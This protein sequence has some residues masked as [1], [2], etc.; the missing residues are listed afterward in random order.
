MHV[1]VQ[2]ANCGGRGHM[3]RMCDR[4]V[5]SFGVV[6]FRVRAGGSLEYMLVQRKD[7]LAYVEFIRGK[8]SLMNTDYIVQMLSNMTRGEQD[9][10]MTCEGF[11]E[12]WNEFW[13]SDTTRNFVKEYEQSSSR[14]SALW[15]GYVT[16]KGIEFSLEKALIECRRL[17][18]PY[19]ETEFGFPKGRRNINESDVC[20][21]CREFSEET[22]MSLAEIALV[23]GMLPFEETFWGSNHVRYRHTYFV[24]KY[25][26]KDDEVENAMPTNQ[27][28]E[29][30]L[31][32]PLQMREI[33]AMG[34]FDADG[35][36]ARLRPHY[37]ERRALFRQIHGLIRRA[38]S[39]PRE[40]DDI[41]V[42][43]IR[44]V[45]SISTSG[46][47]VPLHLTAQV[48]QRPPG[49]HDA[50]AALHLRRAQAILGPVEDVEHA[51]EQLIGVMEG[52]CAACSCYLAADA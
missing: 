41:E 26:G 42:R 51:A 22:G 47:P 12:L 24:A 20:C 31:S 4:P 2:C 28:I 48:L 5:S 50:D 43:C 46:D 36:L 11:D 27:A 35:V 10:L 21:A 38:M 29:T 23:H 8:Y 14:F 37:A 32:N 1:D 3:Y 18:P 30:T 25:I 19:E 17:R 49:F 52:E 33:R 39:S 45:L 40:D 16:A 44:R 9:R 6:C 7:S 13:Q 15:S 34:W